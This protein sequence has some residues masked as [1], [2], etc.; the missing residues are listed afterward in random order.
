MSEIHDAVRGVT[1]AQAARRLGVTQPRLNELLRGKLHK[2]SLDA[3][4]NMLAAAGMRVELRVK[5]A[6]W[7]TGADVLEDA[8]RR[9]GDPRLRTRKKARRGRAY[10]SKDVHRFPT[11]DPARRRRSE[12]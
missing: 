10:T 5:R 6:A 1:Q 3:L 12:S 8:A 7:E 2:F 9:M 4:V 11:A